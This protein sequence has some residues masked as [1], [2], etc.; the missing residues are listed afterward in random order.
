MT[1]W[2]TRA[3]S[4]NSTPV[5]LDEKLLNEEVVILLQGWNAFNNPIYS[6]LKLTLGNLQKLKKAAL[7]R[8]NFLPSDFGTVLSAGTGDP[9]KELHSEMS[10]T[11]GL[12][13]VPKPRM[14]KISTAQP[15]V[16]TEDD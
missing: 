15:S 4:K 5:E 14:P 12:V 16:W 11:Y 10:V 3:F 13:D 7:N 1:E 2:V 8:E 6:Y 9:S